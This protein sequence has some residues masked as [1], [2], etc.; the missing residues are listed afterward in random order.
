MGF[1]TT[2]VL[3]FNGK[4]IFGYQERPLKVSLKL[5]DKSSRNKILKLTNAIPIEKRVVVAIWQL[6]TGDSC[7]AVGKTFRIG[8][9]TAVSIT[10]NFYKGLSKISRR[11]IRFPKSRS[12]TRSSIG[13][14]KEE[15]NCKTPQVLRAVDCTH[16]KILPPANEDKKDYFSR[17]QCHTINTQAAIGANLK[18]LDLAMGFPGSIHDAGALRK[19]SIYRKA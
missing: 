15:T 1:G 2:R 6:A 12:E 7:R 8:K 18:I 14:F 11:F 4:M 3:I 10:H 16:F 9:S 13:D 5:Y 19:T 17:K